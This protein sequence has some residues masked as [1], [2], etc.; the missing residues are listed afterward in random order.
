M[1]AWMHACMDTCMD[2]WMDAC[3]NVCMY[4]E[5]IQGGRGGLSPATFSVC[6][7]RLRCVSSL[8]HTFLLRLFIFVKHIMFKQSLT[9]DKSRCFRL[10]TG[11]T[12]YP[13]AWPTIF[14]DFN[15]FWW[16]QTNYPS[17]SHPG[18]GL[19][20]SWIH[21]GSILHPS[22]IHPRSILD[23]FNQLI[24]QPNNQ[25]NNQSIN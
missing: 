6:I 15:Q 13:N 9:R 7:R 1:D 12:T 8:F 18:S 14:D 25:P 22:P 5:S 11:I 21:P 17:T 16:C 23:P 4:A 3:M 20:P 24:N 19:D 2:A 10:I